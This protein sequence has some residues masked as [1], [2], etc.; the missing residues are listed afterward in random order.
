MQQYNKAWAALLPLAVMIG[1]WLG[2]DVTP[3]WWMGLGAILAPVLVFVVP[4]RHGGG[5]GP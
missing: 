3:D 2:M 5:G 1:G 4:N